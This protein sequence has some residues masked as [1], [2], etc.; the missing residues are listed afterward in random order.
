MIEETLVYYKETKRC[1]VFQSTQLKPA[2]ETFYLQK[3]AMPQDAPIPAQIKVTI[4][5]LK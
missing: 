2:V 5:V 4:E 1:V 3:S